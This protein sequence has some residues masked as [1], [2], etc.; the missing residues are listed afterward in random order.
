MNFYSNTCKEKYPIVSWL[1]CIILALVNNYMNV[2][3]EVIMPTSVMKCSA[4]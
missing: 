3:T 1:Q 4:R 2:S